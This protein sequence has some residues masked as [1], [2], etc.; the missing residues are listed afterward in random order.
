MIKFTIS[1]CTL[2]LCGVMAK[3]QDFPV[4][5]PIDYGAGRSTSPIQDDVEE[6]TPEIIT[7]YAI[8]DMT[9][10]VKKVKT[11][12]MFGN[13][14]NRIVGFKDLADRYWS[15]ASGSVRRLQVSEE[16]ADKFE[17]KGYL[18]GYLIYF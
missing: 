14:S 11:K 2:L 7:A 3:A 4:Y 13:A 15:P 8:N 17:Y 18:N 1:F 12:V 9:R 6:V 10:A 5:K 16:Y